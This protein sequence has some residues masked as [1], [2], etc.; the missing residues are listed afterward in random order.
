MGKVILKAPKERADHVLL[1]LGG[2]NRRARTRTIIDLHFAK[3]RNNEEQMG[4]VILRATIYI[5][6]CT[7]K[8]KIRSHIL[9]ISS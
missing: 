3:D 9:F 7:Y 2:P 6:T 4:R 8:G 1:Y 5:P